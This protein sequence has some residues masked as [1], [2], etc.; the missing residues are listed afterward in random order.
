MKSLLSKIKNKISGFISEFYR[1]P[2]CVPAWGWTEHLIILK[3]ILAGQ[4]IHGPHIKALYEIVRRKT[5]KKYVIGYNSGREA[6]QSVL[7]AHGLGQKDKVILPS[8]CCE[9]VAQAVIDSGATPIFCDVNEDYNPDVNHILRLV[10]SEVKAII[11]PHLFGKPGR[12]DLL[13]AALEKR[14]LRSQI[15][16][17]DDAAQSFGARLN[18]RLVGTFGDA[19]IISFGPGK[20]MT[21]SG[22]GLIITDSEKLTQNIDIMKSLPLNGKVKIKKL[23]YWVVFRRWRKYSLPFYPFIDRWLVSN[24]TADDKVFQMANVDSAIA[25]I[26]IKKLK[27]L[28]NVRLER[29]EKLNLLFDA[30]KLSDSY[31]F[32]GS[33]EEDKAVLNVAT[34]FLAKPIH[35]IENI[36]NIYYK[37]LRENNIE[38]KCLYT[39]I[40]FGKDFKHICSRLP[41]TEGLWDQVLQIPVEP[42]ID[43]KQ[44][45]KM[46]SK[47][48]LFYQLISEKSHATP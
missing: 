18:H 5:E 3:C 20:T 15:L 28:L 43:D 16:L 21:A 7:T 13:E 32:D 19:G 4:I 44:F 34:K 9:T 2:Y 6:I 14:N 37:Y 46:V 23:I 35:R 47:I 48:V 42:S 27:K 39:P 38:M 41:V 40:H 36:Q 1:I 17:I 30:N 26:Q 33:V 12:I 10:S 24:I 45:E 29:K 31:I 11:F 22:G 25:I 8:Y